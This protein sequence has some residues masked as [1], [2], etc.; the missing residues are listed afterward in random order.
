[1]LRHCCFIRQMEIT[2]ELLIGYD[3]FLALPDCEKK[4]TKLIE[5]LDILYNVDSSEIPPDCISSLFCHVVSKF[6]EHVIITVANKIWDA[7]RNIQAIAEFIKTKN[8]PT[9]EERILLF[10]HDLV[11]DEN[12]V[13]DKI[14]EDFTAICG[15]LEEIKYIF[16]LKNED[17][18]FFFPIG[19]LLQKVMT[20]YRELQQLDQNIINTFILAM[21]M[22]TLENDLSNINAL[23]SIVDKFHLEGLKILFKGN[24]V[25]SSWRE[26]LRQ[27][28]VLVL[29][30][31][32]MHKI[33][34]R[35]EDESYFSNLNDRGK[36]C[37]EKNSQGKT[38]A[39]YVLIEY[40]EDA[41]FISLKDVFTN[42]DYDLEMRLKVIDMIFNGKYYNVLSDNCFVK[43]GNEIKVVNEF[44]YKDNKIVI[45]NKS[46][47]VNAIPENIFKYGLHKYDLNILWGND[48]DY[49]MYGSLFR[50]L[51]LSPIA[52]NEVSSKMNKVKSSFQ[53]NLISLWM[54]N[55]K[56]IEFFLPRIVDS[57]FNDINYIRTKGDIENKKIE[58]IYWLPY[59]FPINFIIDKINSICKTQEK[60]FQVVE[61]EVRKTLNG[62]LNFFCKNQIIKSRKIIGNSSINKEQL[63]YAFKKKKKYYINDDASTYLK[64]LSIVQQKNDGIKSI[65]DFSFCSKMEME[66]IR[67]K[68]ELQK[69]ALIPSKNGFFCNFNSMANL[70][71]IHHLIYNSFSK[72]KWAIFIDLLDRHQEVSYSKAINTISYSFDD[73]N[74]LYVPKEDRGQCGTLSDINDKYIKDKSRRDLGLYVERLEKKS[75]LYTV[76]GYEI[77]K[78]VLV[79]DVLQSGAS[80]K[81]YLNSFFEPDKDS[82]IHIHN[83][84]CEEE[85]ISLSQIVESNKPEIQ[86]LFLYGTDEGTNCI[87]NYIKTNIFLKDAEIIC[88]KN[89]DVSPADGEF[90]KKIRTIYEFRDDGEIPKQ[91][92]YPIIRE[93]NQ[94]KKNIFPSELLN[95][96]N[97]ASLFVKKPELR[98][99]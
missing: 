84:Y 26:N 54:E 24:Q 38:I 67:H 61:I 12:Q 56:N 74:T 81:K 20:S 89:I 14:F 42:P 90:C 23:N 95:P 99:S 92:F 25:Y 13:S 3:E 48:V 53:D 18:K 69:E 50:L 75:S 49:V 1:M 91:G 21:E 44:S 98:M 77:K 79:F 86:I 46:Q 40:S 11:N 82:K 9:T 93:F 85:K 65:R 51:L 76:N 33:Y 88:L 66:N 80:T 2:K 52:L 22:F 97:I 35:N 16:L 37:E 94:P 5:I 71:I 64:L 57:Y 63:Y 10:L 72:R 41:D 68:M 39:Y 32:Y 47:A 58:D 15:E 70:R 45:G 8:K 4:E 27:N 7:F 30:D 73:K 36:L 59:K 96:S 31:K 78:L 43:Q 87:K 83:Y 34:I 19:A 28:K 6:N 55:L 17:Q 29:V 62:E 60:T